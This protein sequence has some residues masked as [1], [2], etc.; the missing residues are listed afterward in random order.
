MKR[1]SITVHGDGNVT[2]VCGMEFMFVEDANAHMIT[3][4]KATEIG[5]RE[6]ERLRAYDPTT[7][8]G[9][10]KEA[11]ARVINRE[12]AAPPFAGAHPALVQSILRL[13]D[14]TAGEAARDVV[15]LLHHTN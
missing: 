3:V 5:P 8:H 11:I 12:L 1:H 2:C 15:T 13:V 6:L 7:I 14:V 10:I 9:T 4:A